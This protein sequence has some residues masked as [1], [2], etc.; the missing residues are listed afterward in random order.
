ARAR[1]DGT[2]AAVSPRGSDA[3]A[4]AAATSRA[5][6][7]PGASHSGGTGGS[8]STGGSRSTD[9]TGGAGG[10]SP[11]AAAFTLGSAGDRGQPCNQKKAARR[12]RRLGSRH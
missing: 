2:G 4:A 3:R 1:I 6:P 5:A 8:G 10:A 7:E 11:H 9:G 12:E